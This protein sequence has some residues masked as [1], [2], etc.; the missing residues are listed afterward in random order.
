MLG[1]VRKADL[2]LGLALGAVVGIVICAA[3]V[4]TLY[5]FYPHLFEPFLTHPVI[6]DR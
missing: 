5:F 3:L 1:K 4:T 2:L 6:I